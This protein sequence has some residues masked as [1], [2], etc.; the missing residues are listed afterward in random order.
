MK[1]DMDLCRKILLAVEAYDGPVSYLPDLFPQLSVGDQQRLFDHARLLAQGGLLEGGETT[2][3]LTWQ[4]HE[5]LDLARSDTRWN[6]ATSKVKSAAG[7]V[8]LA[9]VTQLLTQLAKSALGLP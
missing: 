5:L 2:W 7:T 3:S 6:A 4:G 8:S 1:R 9:L